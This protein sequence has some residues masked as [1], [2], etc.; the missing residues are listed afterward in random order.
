VYVQLFGA[1]GTALSE[2]LS[3]LP[4]ELEAILPA[5]QTVALAGDMADAVLQALADRVP[6]MLRLSGPDLPDA[7]VVA[8]IAARRIAS[9]TMDADAPPPGALYLRPPDAIPVA[10]RKANGK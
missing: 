1:D 6:P 8:R 5:A 3:K 4:E 2:P 7:A 9:E 10:E